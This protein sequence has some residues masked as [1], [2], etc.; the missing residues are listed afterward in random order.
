M[1]SSG[2]CDHSPC[3]PR[4]LLA[5]AHPGHE[6]FVHGWLEQSRPLVA[7]LTDGSGRCKASRLHYTSAVMAS[8][9]AAPSS[10]FGAY[11]D[12]RIYEALLN[13]EHPLFVELGNALVDLLVAQSIELVVG[14]AYERAILTHDVWRALVDGAVAKASR[15]TQRGITNLEFPIEPEQTNSTSDPAKRHASAGH[16]NLTSVNAKELSSVAVARKLRAAE[17]Y[18][19]L[20][21]EISAL[22]QARGR[23]WMAY[24]SFSPSRAVWTKD[25]P[26][27][28]PRYEVHGRRL[29]ENQLYPEVIGFERHVRPLFERLQEWSEVG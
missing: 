9:G 2:R 12:R 4:A 22:L 27:R 18:E 17:A 20:Q 29:V 7:I 11:S 25:C 10:L 3:P 5:I 21:V 28:P 23:E 15:C 8:A 19:P 24:E 16:A 1:P 13:Q 14:D 6:L 26:T